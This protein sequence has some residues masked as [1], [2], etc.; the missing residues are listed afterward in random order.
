MTAQQ[1]AGPAADR[2][3]RHGPPDRGQHGNFEGRSNAPANF[4]RNPNENRFASRPGN[5][6]FSGQHRD[7][8]GFRDFHRDF[9]AP[10]QFR[11]AP[12]RAPMGYHPQHWSFGEFLPR[13]YW[14]R[15]YWLMD[16]GDYGLPPPPYGAV[17]VRVGPDA[18]LIDEY[19]GEII[20]VA[21][22]VF[23]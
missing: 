7:F 16:F 22:D 13:P 12:Y 15:D 18:L 8:S 6:T 17:W 1:P 10:H 19:S 5:P 9:R 2:G 14:V 3:E 4:N 11:A 23:Y 20:T 21:Y